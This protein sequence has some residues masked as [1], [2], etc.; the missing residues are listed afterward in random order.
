MQGA[1]LAAAGRTVRYVPQDVAAVQ[2]SET[3]AEFARVGMGG[4]V[5]MPHKEA[6]FVATARPSP[7]ADRLGAVNTFWHEQGVLCGH[8][9]DVAGVQAT[10][11][12]L[13]PGGLSGRPVALLGAGG[14]AAAAL[15]ALELCGCSEIRVAAR[16]PD[17]ARA[18]ADR[19]RV[20]IAI[21]AH[22][23]A[24]VDGVALVV[25]ATPVGMRDDLMPV[26]PT[27]LPSDAAV[28]DL[29][30]RRGATSWVRAARACGLRADDGL[31]M[32]V[33]QG[34]EAFR[35]WFD[36]E[37]SLDAMWRAVESPETSS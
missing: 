30:Y 33:E 18:L 15:V 14:S 28:F 22:A 31:R 35:V 10:L 3:L 5:T 12:A 27:L 24:A 9:T 16:T 36:A 32:L 26:D 2:L 7:L 17:R 37:P 6:V 11:R 20:T 13:C 34:A 1:A 29:V 4:N 8:N 23:E 25:N 21:V 19:V